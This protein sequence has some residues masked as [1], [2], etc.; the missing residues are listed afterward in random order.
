M[1]GSLQGWRGRVFPART[2]IGLDPGA[3]AAAPGV[4][5]L[6][7]GWGR[8][9]LRSCALAELSGALRRQWASGVRCTCALPPSEGLAVPLEAPRLAAARRRT[10]LPGLLDL[11]L[12]FPLEQCACAFVEPPGSR[13]VG[14]AVRHADLRRALEAWRRR[15]GD[16]ERCV[17]LEW[18]LW[19]QALREH[20]VGNGAAAEAGGRVVVLAAGERLVV[21]TGKGVAFGSAA[22]VRRDDP[23][24]LRRILAMAFGRS[25][26]GLLCLCAGGDAQALAGELAALLD[27]GS[28]A[29]QCV[30]SPG[31]FVARGLAWDGFADPEGRAQVRQPPFEHPAAVRRRRWRARRNRGLVLASALLLFGTSLGLRSALARREERQRALLAERLETVAGYPVAT[32]GARAVAEAG[33]ALEERLDP[34]VERFRQ[35]GAE[36]VLPQILEAAAAA[37]VRLTHLALDGRAATLSGRAVAPGAAEAFEGRLRAA[38]LGVRLQRDSIA[39]AAGEVR[40]FMTPEDR[41]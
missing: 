15:G 24:A 13:P 1:R 28:G 30:S 5:L 11:S 25:A 21:V 10:V 20:P 35:P 17:P 36:Q 31:E 26:Q 2:W 22:A 23:A 3:G 12:P 18:V 32:R 16:P 41:P 37:G 8:V 4:A 6:R 14:L 38:G 7:A 29:V 19:N 27:P 40:F 39:D 9:R 34:V 33:A